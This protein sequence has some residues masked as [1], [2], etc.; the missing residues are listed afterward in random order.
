MTMNKS[1]QNLTFFSWS[2]SNNTYF[3]T[4]KHPNMCQ[5]P[6]SINF[7]FAT[8]TPYPELTRICSHVRP[9]DINFHSLSE[10]H[11]WSHNNRVHLAIQTK[12][13]NKL[14]FFCFFFTTTS[15]DHNFAWPQL[16]LT[17]TSPGHNFA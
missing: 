14:F 4:Q 16:R 12:T 15:P 7:P 13:P 8:S 2:T 6:V 17:T 11:F 3:L 1:E 10:Q 5:Y 9:K